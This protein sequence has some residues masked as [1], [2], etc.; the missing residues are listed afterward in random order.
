MFLDAE[1]L[2]S[3]RMFEFVFRMFSMGDA[4]VPARGMGA[5]ARQ[6]AKSLPMLWA[7]TH[8]GKGDNEGV[9]FHGCLPSR[10][11]AQR[12]LK[13]RP[14]CRSRSSRVTSCLRAK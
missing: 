13:G 8:Q 12:E 14:R 3:S 2:T 6:I 5:M 11:Q 1:L 7:M 10:L 4:A 9:Q